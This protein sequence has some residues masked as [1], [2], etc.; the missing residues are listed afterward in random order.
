MNW[1]ETFINLTHS[2]AI[3]SKDT[4]TKV[5]AVIV[6]QSNEIISC[7]YN[8][9][10]RGLDDNK[11]E[12]HIRPLKYKYFEHAERNAIYNAARIG[13]STLNSVIYCN[14]HPCSDCMRG[15]IQSGIKKIYIHKEFVNEFFKFHNTNNVW[16]EDMELAKNMADEV[17]IPIEYVSTKIVIPKPIINGKDIDLF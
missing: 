7:G 10:A 13:S 8:G 16:K 9:L 1:N 15:I 4:S 2:I 6:G 14:L 5:G 3:K 17:N 11:E 12:R